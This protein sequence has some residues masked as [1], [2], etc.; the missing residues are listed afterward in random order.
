MKG[1]TYLINLLL[2]STCPQTENSQICASEEVCSVMHYVL[3]DIN[4]LTAKQSYSLLNVT[5]KHKQVFVFDIDI[6]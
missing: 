4:I 2:S 3:H 6:T 1:L 5:E